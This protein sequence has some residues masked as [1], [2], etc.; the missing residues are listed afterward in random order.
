MAPVFDLCFLPAGGVP[1]DVVVGETDEGVSV[2]VG[3][4]VS[5]VAADDELGVMVVRTD[6]VDGT[7]VEPLDTAVVCTTRLVKGEVAGEETAGADDWSSVVAIVVGTARVVCTTDDPIVVSGTVCTTLLVIAD[8]I[9][10]DVSCVDGRIGVIVVK[11]DWDK[12][13]MD[14]PLVE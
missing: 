14:E 5:V 8:V 13:M 7:T 4:P 12:E 3:D 2:T 9:G 10:A 6:C 11:I 1:V